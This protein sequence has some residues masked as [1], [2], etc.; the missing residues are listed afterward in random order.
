[1]SRALKLIGWVT[2]NGAEVDANNNLKINPPTTIAQAGFTAVAGRNDDGAVTGT[3]RVNRVY[4][5]EGQRLAVAPG[6]LL[7]DDT[8]NATAQNTAKYRAPIAT[9][10]VTF[11]GGYAIINGASITTINTNAALQSYRTFPLFAKAELRCN[12]A[13]MITAVP[14]ANCVTEMGLFSAT[15]PGAAA[16]TDGI[17]FRW[18]A[19]GELR[20]VSSYAG[21]ETQTAAITSPSVGVNHDYTIVVQ[22]NVVLFYIDDV[23]QA[24]ILLLTGAPTLGQPQ[25]MGAQPF[26]ARQYIAGSAPALA[27]QLKISDVFVTVLG[28]D[29]KKP[30]SETKSGMGHCAYQ[31]QNGG[32]MGSLAQYANSANPAA[33]VPTNTTAALGSGLGGL[34]QETVSLA[35][36]TDGI[37]SSF[38]NPVGSL[39]QTPRVLYITGVV[40]DGTVVVVLGAGAGYCAVWSLA[41]GHTAVS[42]ATAESATA[43]APRRVPLGIMAVGATQAVGTRIGTTPLWTQFATPIPV[44]PGEFIQAVSRK[45]GV[46]PPTG[47]ILWSIT[48][49]GYFE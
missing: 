32:T 42:L 40:I 22:T 30:W 17:F 27:S 43:K 9:M 36:T 26:T 28:P 6:A 10:T 12:I 3:P 31:G 45:V 41:F 44:N 1:M 4:V 23:L 39:T 48:F 7:W 21:T 11:V 33:A 19:A 49:D 29:F 37:I 8:F 5:T 16:P 13:A 34:F 18:N 25:Q 35:V 15:L 38:Q 2:G 24:T 46:A 20:G 14:Q 47:A